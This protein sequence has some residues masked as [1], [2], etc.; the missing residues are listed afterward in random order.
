MIRKSCERVRPLAAVSGQRLTVSAAGRRVDASRG[1]RNLFVH[2]GQILIAFNRRYVLVPCQLIDA[3][4]VLVSMLERDFGWGCR[5]PIRGPSL[6]V[7]FFS[8]RHHDHSVF[9]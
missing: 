5:N 4:T 7:R 2:I 1:L 8:P 6:A 9:N 3:M